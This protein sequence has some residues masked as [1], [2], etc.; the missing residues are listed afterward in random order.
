MAFPAQFESIFEHDAH[1]LPQRVDQRNRWRVVIQPVLAPVIH[2]RGKI[3]I[4][5]LH[6]R[7]ASAKNLF[8]AWAYRNRGHPRRRADCLLRATETNVNNMLIYM[9]RYCRQRGDGIYDKK[10]AVLV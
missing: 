6:L 2:R 1:R 8:R 5:A 3:E 9:K 10:C 7:L 4:P